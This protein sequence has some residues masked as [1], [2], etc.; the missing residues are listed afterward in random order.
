MVDNLTARLE[1][2]VM[3]TESM[4]QLPADIPK[5]GAIGESKLQ[6]VLQILEAMV[7]SAMEVADHR[8]GSLVNAHAKLNSE[9][10][11]KE[12][13]QKELAAVRSELEEM[14]AKWANAQTE[15]FAAERQQQV[16]NHAEPRYAMREYES[17]LIPYVPSLLLFSVAPRV[18]TAGSRSRESPLL[19]DEGMLGDGHASVDR[20]TRW[21]KF[22]SEQPRWSLRIVHRCIRRRRERRGRSAGERSTGGVLL[23]QWSC[24]LLRRLLEEGGQSLGTCELCS[25][26]LLLLTTCWCVCVSPAGGGGMHSSAHKC[27]ALACACE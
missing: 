2:L 7:Q 15:S 10:L 24:Q 25:L 26:L 12:A 21:S 22:A 14:Q 11:E 17:I 19:P 23:F 9:A 5:D 27:A 6:T 18:R 20:R 8:T 13:I 1:A 16:W 3:R 4:S